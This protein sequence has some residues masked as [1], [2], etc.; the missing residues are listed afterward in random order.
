MPPYDQPPT[1]S[2]FGSA[3]PRLH[4][5][6][7]GGENVLHV[8]VR[9]SRHR[10][11]LAI[12]LAAARTAARIGG[13]RRHNHAPREIC[14]SKCSSGN[15]HC[16]TGPPWIRRIAGS[17]CAPPARRLHEIAVH[18]RAVLAFERD[19][20]HLR[21]ALRLSAIRSGGRSGAARLCRPTHRLRRAPVGVADQQRVAAVRV[22]L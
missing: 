2:R 13:D 1:H 17:A 9:P 18:L 10:C 6:I 5:V 3:T 21:R 16:S 7:D 20:L 14:Q 12:C 22:A 8:A 19:L 4:R 11:A 15:S